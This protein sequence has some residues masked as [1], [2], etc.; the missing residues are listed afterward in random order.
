MNP[1]AS[2]SLPCSRGKD[3]ADHRAKPKHPNN[4][5]GAH[6]LLNGL[7]TI[8]DGGQQRK[9]LVFKRIAIGLDLA[10]KIAELL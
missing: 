5:F 10:R 2:A 1:C 4:V 7:V 8:A 6:N 9:I 3:F